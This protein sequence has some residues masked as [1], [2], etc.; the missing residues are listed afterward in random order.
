MKIFPIFLII[1]MTL[2]VNAYSRSCPADNTPESQVCIANMLNDAASDQLFT[3][4]A[5]VGGI[6]GGV[7]YYLVNKK[8]IDEKEKQMML[9]DFK[10]GNG[11]PI[12]KK[13]NLGLFYYKQNKSF[14]YTKDLTQDLSSINSPF[15]QIL[16]LEYKLN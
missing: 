9:E 13:G 16:S 6:A 7:G 3:T 11:I 14:N 1:V 10:S 8:E 4:L 12:F 5:I 15:I 2:S